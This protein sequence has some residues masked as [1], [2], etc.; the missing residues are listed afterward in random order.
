MKS[1]IESFLFKPVVIQLVEPIAAVHSVEEVTDEA[2]EKPVTYGR[3]VM[4][5][6]KKAVMDPQ[7]RQPVAQDSPIL[8]QV[9]QGEIDSVS[10]DGFIFTTLGGDGKTQVAIYT[11]FNNVRAVTF[12]L[13]HVEATPEAEPSRIIQN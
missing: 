5:I 9:L 2:D 6:M 11:H 12:A 8:Q 7:T 1:C 4:S 3:A 13:E 10:E